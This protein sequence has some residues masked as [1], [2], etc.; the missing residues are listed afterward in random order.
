MHLAKKYKLSLIS[1]KLNEKNQGKGTKIFH[2][3]EPIEFIRSAFESAHANLAYEMNPQGI[4]GNICICM[5][6]MCVVC[7]CAKEFL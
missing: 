4:D 3:H 5:K 6:A 2:L 1:K 7:A